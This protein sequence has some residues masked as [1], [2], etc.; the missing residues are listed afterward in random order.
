MVSDHHYM[1]ICYVYPA[2]FVRKLHFPGTR[3][4]TSRWSDMTSL[5][6]LQRR[7]LYIKTAVVL[8]KLPTAIGMVLYTAPIFSVKVADGCNH[9]ISGSPSWTLPRASS[10]SIAHPGGIFGGNSQLGR[11]KPISPSKPPETLRTST[12]PPT[13]SLSKRRHDLPFQAVSPQIGLSRIATNSGPKQTIGKFMSA[14]FSDGETCYLFIFISSFCK[15][16]GSLNPVPMMI[17]GS[18][19][20]ALPSAIPLKTGCL[21]GF[22]IMDCDPP[23]Y[24][25]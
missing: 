25:G 12:T 24:I 2:S 20:A 16:A 18:S 6:H 10:G 11:F 1:T 22:P 15:F 3:T 8:V 7:P 23:Q 13:P 21:L 14:R 5:F 19:S 4:P 17:V 9:S